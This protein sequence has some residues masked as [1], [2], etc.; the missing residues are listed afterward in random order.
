[1]REI[2]SGLAKN[3]FEVAKSV[4]VLDAILLSVESWEKISN[5]TIVNCWRKGGLLPSTGEDVGQDALPRPANITREQ[6]ETFLAFDDDLPTERPLDDQ[7]II[8]EVTR[9]ADDD[10]EDDAEKPPTGAEI[11]VASRTLKRAFLSNG[12]DFSFIRQLENTSNT[13]A[14][15]SMK[16]QDGIAVNDLQRN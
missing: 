15:K 16:K 3:G 10:E 12:V 11:L 14:L 9:E 4:S 6:F 7:E 13:V 2:D 5:Q 1:M 8:G